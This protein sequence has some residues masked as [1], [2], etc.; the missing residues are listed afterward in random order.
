[1]DISRTDRAG[2]RWR[3]P[4]AGLLG[5]ALFAAA[6]GDSDERTAQEIY[7]DAG[8]SLQASVDSLISIDIVAVG[9]NGVEDALDQVVDSAGDL[10]DSVSEAAKD[11]TAALEQAVDDTKSAASALGDEATSENVSAML[12]AITALEASASAVYATLTDCP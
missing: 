5:L 3:R 1:M 12:A 7:C 6:C 8:D 4:V 9:T 11:E 2:G 10:A